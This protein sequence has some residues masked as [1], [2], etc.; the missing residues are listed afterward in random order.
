VQIDSANLDGHKLLAMSAARTGHISC[1]LAEFELVLGKDPG[2]AW[3]W[4]N[5]GRVLM[6]EREFGRAR[7]AF[8][9]ALLLRPGDP[10]A[11][12]AL[13]EWSAARAPR[14]SA[15][16]LTFTN[17]DRFSVWAQTAGLR[18]SLGDAAQLTIEAGELDFRKS[19][20]QL[21]RAELNGTLAFQVPPAVSLE[22]WTG[23]SVDT[24]ANRR[25]SGGAGG[26]W[27]RQDGTLYFSASAG[28]PVFPDTF[29]AAELDITGSQFA[30]GIEQAAGLSS[31]FQ[32]IAEYGLYSDH[33]RRLHTEARLAR[34]W[35]FREGVF[36]RLEYESISFSARSANY[37]SPDLF[38]MVR[39]RVGFSSPLA[40]GLGADGSAALVYAPGERPIGRS[41]SLSARMEDRRLSIRASGTYDMVPGAREWSGN[42]VRIEGAWTF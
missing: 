12:R 13:R 36:T 41:L 29:Q 17:S 40:H 19:N 37:F 6:A 22:F 30:L 32:G 31:S 4:V 16:T 28:S 25:I 9:Q 21:S 23:A 34:K 20:S 26:Q 27:T 33:N 42:S 39:A 8:L 15:S 14:V 38:Q 7:L 1:A 18:T 2:D 35:R 24:L 3:M 10:S 5:F 11:E